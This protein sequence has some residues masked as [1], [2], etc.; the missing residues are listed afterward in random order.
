MTSR[1]EENREFTQIKKQIYQQS[2]LSELQNS[3]FFLKHKSNDY[4]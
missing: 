3:V 4:P 2:Y 1:Q